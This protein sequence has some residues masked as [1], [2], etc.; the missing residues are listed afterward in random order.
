MNLAFVLCVM[1]YA[2]ALD[3]T[4]GRD[5][6]GTV[7]GEATRVK[8]PEKGDL[9]FADWADYNIE[10]FAADY[11]AWSYGDRSRPKWLG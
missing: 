8:L 4:K 3:R 2:V 9:C 1:T 5:I 6:G 7:V 10:D 11:V